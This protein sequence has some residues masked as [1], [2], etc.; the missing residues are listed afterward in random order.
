M[1]LAL[2]VR[3]EALRDR[4]QRISSRAAIVRATP[5]SVSVPT[6]IRSVM[7][8]RRSIA[9]RRVAGR[10]QVTFTLISP[11]EKRYGR[12]T[13][14]PAR[15]KA[16]QGRT[17]TLTVPGTVA[18]IM[19]I[20]CTGETRRVRQRQGRYGHKSRETSRGVGRQRPSAATTA[21]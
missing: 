15:E 10:R 1:A 13:T 20:G 19:H 11:R 3:G 7:E 16:C 5:S 17:F 21:L 6:P 4:L 18:V 14:N 9:R 2:A 8:G 12:T